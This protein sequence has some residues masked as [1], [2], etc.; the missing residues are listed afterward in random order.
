MIDELKSLLNMIDKMPDMVM[1]VLLGFAVYKTILFL[2]TSA[3][4]YGTLRLAINKLHDYKVRPR[5]TIIKYDYKT[6]MID[7][8]THAEIEAIFLRLRTI[9]VLKG[10]RKEPFVHIHFSDAKYLSDALDEKIQR[11]IYKKEEV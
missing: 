4:I 9:S 5:E 10:F 8:Q 1:H 6:Y 2:G 7:S 3:G 11:D